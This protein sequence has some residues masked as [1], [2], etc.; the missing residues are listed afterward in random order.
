[1]GSKEEPFFGKNIKEALR[2]Y[3]EFMEKGIKHGRRTDLQGG[4]LVR[5]AVGATS[6]L[7]S[8]DKESC[9]LS[10]QRVLGSANFDAGVLKEANELDK[11]RK[12]EE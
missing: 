8:K 12:K 9:E 5:S 6:V 1:M 11:H 2:R 3:R 7:F 4:G 10:D